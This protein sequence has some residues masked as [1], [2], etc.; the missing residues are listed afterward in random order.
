MRLSTAILLGLLC[1]VATFAHADQ[2]EPPPVPPVPPVAPV[3]P[4]PPLPPE[5]PAPPALPPVPAAA[6]AACKGKAEGSVIT[7]TIGKFEVMTG[8][9]RTVKGKTVFELESWHKSK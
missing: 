9:C 5:P 7:Y 1:S 3:M 8:T 4:V 2:Y 6:H